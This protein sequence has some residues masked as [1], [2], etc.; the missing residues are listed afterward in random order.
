MSGFLAGP[1]K[2]LLIER[3]FWIKEEMKPTSPFGIKDIHFCLHI[4]VKESLEDTSTNF[5]VVSTAHISGKANSRLHEKVELT[6]E[7]DD[8]VIPDARKP[9]NRLVLELELIFLF[10]EMSCSLSF[11][12]KHPAQ[13][14]EI[15]KQC[16]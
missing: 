1:I 15:G 8:C 10:F 12:V 2:Q 7:Q 14:M 13:K 6:K 16:I 4:F 5:V 11:I 3:L 9:P